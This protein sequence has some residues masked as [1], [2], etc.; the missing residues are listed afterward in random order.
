MKRR[1][2]TFWRKAGKRLNGYCNLAL[3]FDRNSDGLLHLTREGGHSMRRIAHIADHTGKA[4]IENL[5]HALRKRANIH[6]FERHTALE[7]LKNPEDA[8]ARQKRNVGA[9]FNTDL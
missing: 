1:C 7:V 3:P 4:V 6:V 8:A 9:H 2:A 5:H